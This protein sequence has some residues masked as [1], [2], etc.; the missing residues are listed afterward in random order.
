MRPMIW[1]VVALLLAIAAWNLFRHRGGAVATKEL[2]PPQIEAFL[3]PYRDK[4]RASQRPVARIALE[5]FAADDPAVSKVGGRAWWPERQPVPQG[6]DGK[7]LV[8]LAQI[9]FTELPGLPGYPTRGLVQ[10]FIAGTDFY[11]ANFEG[12][13]APD[14]LAQQR[15]FRVVYWPDLSV[16]AQA[17]PVADSD[18]LPHAPSRP[19]R[20]RFSLDEEP[21]S[22][23]DHRFEALMGGNAYAAAEAYGRAHGIPGDALFDAIAERHGGTGHKV[24]GYPYFTQT[25]PRTGGDW[26]L[27]LQLDS[28][29]EMMWGDAGVGN[30]FIPPADLAR[31]DFSRVLYTWDCH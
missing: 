9:N 3:A 31:A 13:I 8:L 15:D 25:D 10:F 28:D 21:L 30:F 27:L 17:L 5:P 2:E 4:L 23:S 29:D 18:L 16:A 24:G 14:Q 1:I 19:R 22:V 20:M 11:G 7:P 12:G 6:T 26:E